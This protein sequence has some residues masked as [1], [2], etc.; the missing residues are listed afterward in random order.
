[1]MEHKIINAIKDILP[2]LPIYHD[3][4]P[5]KVNIPFLVLQRVGGAG[6]LLFDE[7]IGCYEVRFQLTVWS[8]N[9]LNAIDL[10]NKIEQ[11]LLQLPIIRVAGAAEATF[12]PDVGWRGMRQD[13][14]IIT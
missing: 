13:F 4:A 3:F 6:N 2:N 7:E 14:F 8:D 12:D 11:S 1:M 5:E 9:R 10:S